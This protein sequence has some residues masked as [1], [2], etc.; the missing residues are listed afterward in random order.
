MTVGALYLKIS[1]HLLYPNTPLVLNICWAVLGL[2]LCPKKLIEW[3]QAVLDNGFRTDSSP[4][5]VAE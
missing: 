1:I 2:Q 5:G 3:A 4:I